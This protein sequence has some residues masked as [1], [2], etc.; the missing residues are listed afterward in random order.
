MSAAPSGTASLAADGRRLEWDPPEGKK[1]CRIFEPAEGDVE[2]EA[3]HEKYIEF[4]IDAGERFR[5]AI[6][7]VNGASL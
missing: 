5:N 4:F 7:A 6:S 3:E 1:A 2:N